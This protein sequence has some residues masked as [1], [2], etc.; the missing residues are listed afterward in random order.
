MW[1]AVTDGTQTDRLTLLVTAA[2]APGTRCERWNHTTG[3]WTT[4]SYCA[5]CA[6]RG[7]R[8]YWKLA[9]RAG[10]QL[11]TADACDICGTEID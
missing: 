5:S 9:P 6:A 4:V 11:R 2:H 7:T 3:K 8:S 10:R 1:Y